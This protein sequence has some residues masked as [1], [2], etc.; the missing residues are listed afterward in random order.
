MIDAIEESEPTTTTEKDTYW[1]DLVPLINAS[2][3]TFEVSNPDY[4]EIIQETHLGTGDVGSLRGGEIIVGTEGDDEID[5]DHF[6]GDY[7]IGLQ[8][9]DIINGKFG[10]DTLF[11]RLGDGNDSFFSEA[12]GSDTL[13]VDGNFQQDDLSFYRPNVDDLLISFAQGGSVTIVNF[14]ATTTFGEILFADNSTIS[15]ES[16]LEFFQN[17]EATEYDDFLTGDNQDN[18]IDGLGGD[19]LI[20]G[21]YGKDTLYGGAGDDLIDGGSRNDL[22]NGGSGNDTLEGG[23]GDD[24]FNGGAGD[25]IIFAEGNET[26]DGGTGVDTVELWLVYYDSVDFNLVTQNYSGV[27]YN[28][29][30]HIF[31]MSNIE[32]FIFSTKVDSTIVGTSQS[33]YLFLTT[34][35]D[36]VDGGAGDD[37]IHSLGIAGNLV[38]STTYYYGGNDTIN[39][40]DGDDFISGNATSTY[41]GGA[42]NDTIKV[43]SQGT[44]DINLHTQISSF[45]SF[46]NF[47]NVIVNHPRALSLNI[48]YD[49]EIIGSSS[50]NYLQGIQAEFTIE[51]G[52]GDDTIVGGEF[53]DTL[54][55]GNGNDVFVVLNNSDS[56]FVDSDRITDFVQ[57]QDKID[58]SSLGFDILTNTENM[59]VNEIFVDYISATNE[60]HI[61][62]AYSDFKL[63]LENGNYTVSDTDFIFATSNITGT[64]DNDLLV[65]ANMSDEIHGLEGD[66][67]LQG[68]GGIDTLDGGDGFDIADY[69][70]T[71]E[72]WLINLDINAASIIGGNGV[73]ETLYNLEGV[74]GGSGNDKVYGNDSYN[75]LEGGLGQ[76]SL[77]GFD[78]DDTLDGGAGQDKLT[79]GLGAD[80]FV[81]SDVS[82]SIDDN[83]ANNN[84]YDR[85]TD[86]EV[87]V[88]KIDLTAIDAYQFH[89]AS[90]NT[91]FGEIRISYNSS[92]DR[93]FVISDQSN[94]TIRLDGDYTTSISN[95]GNGV[96]TESDFLLEDIP[97]M[98][99]VGTSAAEAI[100]GTLAH[101]YIEALA[102]DDTIN[103]AAGDDTIDGGAGEDRITTGEGADVI[104]FSDTAHSVRGSAG[105]YDRIT[106]FEVGVDM[107]DLSGLGFNNLVFSTSST[108]ANELRVTLNGAATR[109]YVRNNQTDFEF[110]LDG[111]YTKS[112]AQG[113]EGILSVAD[114]VLDGGVN[115]GSNSSEFMNGTAGSDVLIG[116]NGHDTISGG[117]GDDTLNGGLGIDS[118]TGGDGADIFKFTSISDS[119]SN[120]SK[121]DVISDF[122]LEIDKIDL[123]GLGYDGFISTGT[124]QSGELR[125][126]YN[127]S[128]D[129][130]YI[131]NNQ[132]TFEI[133]LEGDYSALSDND[134]IF[135]EQTEQVILSSSADNHTG[136][137]ASETLL[138]RKGD[139][140]ING[141]AGDDYIDGGQDE[142]RLTGGDGAD[143]FR[144]AHASDSV[145]TGGKF[146]QITDFTVNEDMIDLSG[147]EFTDI[148]FGS[149]ND[150]TSQGELLVSYSSS[151]D[152]TYITDP[153]GS[154]FEFYLKGDYTSSLTESS[155]IFA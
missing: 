102:S 63:I 26:I 103:G 45:G 2:A 125:I 105:F 40:G 109:T 133:V 107:I 52:A 34:G 121:Y 65:G 142:D 153:N 7:I 24:V 37:E 100:N 91:E 143:T 44:F 137:S 76:D 122:E 115:I 14:F 79:G 128:F 88:D 36:S 146:D 70:D 147:M 110:Y 134:F 119:I 95:G 113:G 80:I 53:S 140:T 13:I 85:I 150:P 94:F 89:S 51:G 8:G 35:N 92:Q 145:H 155:F 74:I 67:T 31:D 96:L 130:T 5:G 38:E 151:S 39:G 22:I 90:G 104:R 124:T 47:E 99:T 149:Y 78:G 57:G 132:S 81:F 72:G 66:D 28:D 108:E 98:L 83:G 139:D 123:T 101:D 50:D 48:P 154:D 141:G 42:G 86:F 138:G 148:V 111:D 129:K 61:S 58:V 68:G 18:V 11:Y 27:Y 69:S 59:Q 114:F 16:I 54:M 75:V 29:S 17:Q 43:Y 4:V 126:A 118:L 136:T 152:R 12:T 116:L 33:E 55:G 71:S 82:H 21:E 6:G 49:G 25:D 93:T 19:D 56:D 84:L 135:G 120:S 60:T 77:A 30:T 106:D 9:D 3:D 10:S 32:N 23:N 62:N 20:F 144:F 41:D 127:S 112:I 46:S 15:R 73:L 131:Y 64:S 1:N 97:L 117:A 87:G